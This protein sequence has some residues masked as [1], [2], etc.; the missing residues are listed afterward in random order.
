MK[1]MQITENLYD[2]SLKKIVGRLLDVIPEEELDDCKNFIEEIK[3][4]ESVILEG[5]KIYFEDDVVFPKRKFQKKYPLNPIVNSPIQA[6]VIIIN[7][8]KLKDRF[9]R[10]YSTTFYLCP[11]N[12]WSQM[13]NSSLT[14]ANMSIFRKFVL[15]YYSARSIGLK[16]LEEYAKKLYA[17][18]DK[19]MIN[20][21]CIS[22]GGSNI[23]EENF[24]KVNSMLASSDIGMINMGMRIL[25]GFDYTI[26]KKCISLLLNLN[27]ENI[28]STK[29]KRNVEISSMIERL[30][31]DFPEYSDQTPAFWIKMITENEDDKIVRMA[32][33]KWAKKHYDFKGVLN[34]KL[35]K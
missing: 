34:V 6:D 9:L 28:L 8:D 17:M 1:I 5:E 22:L 15:Q 12:S 14:G 19:K 32:F 7:K 30:D 31:E 11:S 23:D 27:W 35:E 2:H 29:P 24:D 4:S 10:V 25:T 13:Y 16:T 21:A 3:I 26:S 33:N 20:F 18:K